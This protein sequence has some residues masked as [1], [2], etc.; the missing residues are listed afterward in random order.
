MGSNLW[1]NNI[2]KVIGSNIMLIIAG[3]ASSF[4]L[5]KMLSVGGYGMYKIFT[6]Y[7]T[8]IVLL[9]FGFAEGIYV[10]YAGKDYNVL[11][12]TQFSTYTKV[13]LF[14]EV[15]VSLI[16]ATVCVIF[17]KS[18]YLIIGILLASNI[19]A[20]NLTNYFQ[21]ISQATQR[22]TELSIR[23]VLRAFLTIA[24]IISMWILHQK[25][26]YEI[27]YDS[28]TIT[29][30]LINYVLL[31]WYIFTYREIIFNESE[32][33]KNNYEQIKTFFRVGL[34][35]AFSNII[36]SLILII[37]RQLVAIFFSSEVYAIYAFAY[38]ILAIVSTVIAS[39][40]VVL[41][42]LFKQ[43][44]KEYLLKIYPECISLITIL[45]FASLSTYYPLC[46][47]IKTLLPNYI[48]SLIIFRVIFPGLAIS[49]PI[50]VVMHN[51]YKT[52]GI[53]YL[54]FKIC[55]MVLVIS[56]LINSCAYFVF[57][58]IVSISISSVISMLIWYL[59]VEK[60]LEL[61]YHIRAS[62]NVLYI[63]IM[64]ACFYILSSMENLILGTCLYFVT[65]IL[66][67]GIFYHNVIY[68]IIRRRSIYVK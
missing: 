8:Y 29:I 40:A 27:S 43:K 25:F 51:F 18:D 3:V 17:L 49:A 35:L 22:F 68:R 65:L 4:L 62:I 15:I 34:P 39:I 44:S 42:P 41:F 2:M 67:T 45:V 55:L 66:I 54:Y 58:T 30:V 19:L 48:D 61:K 38:S 59:S 57:G 7:T 37:D 47:I 12:R 56:T 46:F 24:V 21:Y 33:I 36:A 64:M 16:V 28:Y 11:S 1:I 32:K 20:V 53:N 9:Q 31:G 26:D 63:I 10:G 5:P 52:F 60:I 6:L 23:N 50:T 13:I 14:M